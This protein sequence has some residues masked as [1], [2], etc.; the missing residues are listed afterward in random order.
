MPQR[1][2]AQRMQLAFQGLD[3]FHETQQYRDGVR[4]E[5]EV[6]AQTGRLARDH[7]AIGREH[8]RARAGIDGR[9][10]TVIDQLAQVVV[11]KPGENQQLGKRYLAVFVQPQCFR[12]VDVHAAAPSL[13]WARGSKFDDSE[14]SRYNERSRSLT[15]VGTTMATIAKR[16][17]DFPSG[18]DSP[19]PANRSCWPARVPA[20]TLSDTAPASVGNSTLVPSTASQGAR[21][22]STYRSRPL[23]RNSGWG[24]T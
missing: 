15:T 16:S 6:P 7:H 21:G 8:P 12:S 20:G 1:A 10:R 3:L 11:G 22:R 5:L 14:S 13:K 4:V 23:V 24:W 19:R 2:G 9:E 17:P 18:R